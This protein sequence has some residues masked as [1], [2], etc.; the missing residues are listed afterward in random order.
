VEED[1]EEAGSEA[2]IL[3]ERALHGGPHQGLQL[4]AGIQ[5]E[6]VVKA[7]TGKSHILISMCRRRRRRAGGIAAEH[8]SCCSLPSSFVALLLLLVG[9]GVPAGHPL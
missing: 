5:V 4:R 2:D 7:T 9:S 8:C 1:A 6:V 3:L